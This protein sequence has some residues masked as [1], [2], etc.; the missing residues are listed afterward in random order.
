M[1]DVT[2]R[3]AK[4]RHK[5]GRTC[6]KCGGSLHDTIVH[7]G[8]KGGLRSPYKWRQAAKAASKSDL[9]ICLGS[10]LKVSESGA[11]I[12]VVLLK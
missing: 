7:F 6:I 11:L 1:F 10:S 5:T 3:T 8:E 4:G 9:I 2:E 12:D